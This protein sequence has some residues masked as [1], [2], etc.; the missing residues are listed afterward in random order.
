MSFISSN[1]K[2]LW[3][4]FSLYWLVLRQSQFIFSLGLALQD[5]Q[6]NQW[7]IIPWSLWP[8]FMKINFNKVSTST[9]RRLQNQTIQ[10]QIYQIL[11]MK[12]CQIF[13]M[14]TFFS[15][16]VRKVIS[17]W[18]WLNSSLR[19]YFSQFGGEEGVHTRWYLIPHLKVFSG[20][21]TLV[22]LTG[23]FFI[24]RRW[25]KLS[26]Y[27]GTCSSFPGESRSARLAFPVV[28]LRCF[29]PPPRGLFS[30]QQQTL[31][32]SLVFASQHVDGCR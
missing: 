28:L 5:T 2:A 30:H 23:H 3:I 19:E 6:I 16:G 10:L 29:F 4:T 9:Q 20:K 24:P 15:P 31:P 17:S 25:K 26:F 11:I 21:Y 13:L 22:Q 18:L 8:E 7:V 27:P 14:L 32:D 1:R 12:I